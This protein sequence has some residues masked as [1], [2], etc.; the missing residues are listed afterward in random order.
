M[1]SSKL[2]TGFLHP[3]PYSN[4]SWFPKSKQ[5]LSWMVKNNFI[6]KD[7][8]SHFGNISSIEKILENH[9]EKILGFKIINLN[10]SELDG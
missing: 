9:V 4:C 8:P 1:P 7:L 6:Y 10:V 5:I 2:G 3:K